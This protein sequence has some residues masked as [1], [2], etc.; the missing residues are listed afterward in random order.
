MRFI[1][2]KEITQ[3]VK[4]AGI[5]DGDIILTH[6]DITRIGMVE[7]CS[8]RESLLKAYYQGLREAVGN[9]GTIVA[10]S[11]TES[12]AKGKPFVYEDSPSEQGVL[13]EYIRTR[14]GAIRSMHP[15]LS[16]CAIGP[17]AELISGDASRSAFGWDSP[18]ERLHRY[19]AKILCIGVDLLSMTFVHHIEQFFGVPYSYSKEWSTPVYCGGRE[20]K[21]R[22]VAFVRYLDCGINYDF[23]RLQ[24]KLFER[25][26]ALKVPLGYGH[27]Y[28][29]KCKDVFNTGIEELDEDLFFFLKH[30]PEKEV[31]KGKKMPS[32]EY[33]EKEIIK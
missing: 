14:P 15:L 11:C 18:F 12:F 24:K 21:K 16:V 33:Y 13:S 23:S 31:W 10:L 1:T 9:D 7:N 3:A 32:L 25:K 28:S 8:S 2:Q 4:E 22:Y 20:D 17:K 26:Q 27:I 6:S 29:V 30:P 19:G 5:K